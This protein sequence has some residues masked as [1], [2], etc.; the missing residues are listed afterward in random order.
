M[1]TP[2]AYGTVR[3]V[4]VAGR[5]PG[6][7]PGRHLGHREGGYVDRRGEQQDQASRGSDEVVPALARRVPGPPPAVEGEEDEARGEVGELLVRSHAERV[8]DQGETPAGEGQPGLGHEHGEGEE[9]DDDGVAAV[10]LGAGG[11]VCRGDK[12]STL[13]LRISSTSL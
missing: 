1:R 2:Q 7:V 10:A 5:S 4:A 6:W 13:F 8:G 12:K 9:E 11:G 3:A